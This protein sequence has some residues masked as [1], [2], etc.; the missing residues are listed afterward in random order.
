M[1]KMIVLATALSTASSLF[2]ADPTLVPYPEATVSGHM[3][4]A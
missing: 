2:A 4:R 3:S 1:R